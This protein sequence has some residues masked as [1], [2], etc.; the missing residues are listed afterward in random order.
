RRHGVCSAAGR[1]Q[2]QGIEF[3]GNGASGT[4]LTLLIAP[5]AFTS[6]SGVAADGARVRTTSDNNIR[7]VSGADMVLDRPGPPV[8]DPDTTSGLMGWVDTSTGSG[9]IDITQL[10]GSTIT[11]T[12][13]ESLIGI[14]GLQEGL[15]DVFLSSAGIINV[16]AAGIGNFGIHGV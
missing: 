7:I 8:G 10:A 5:N 14:C 3:N 13:S 2:R 1:V 11:M 15:G 12:G 4:E 6:T 9:W 16:T